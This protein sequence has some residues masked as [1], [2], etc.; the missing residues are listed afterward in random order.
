LGNFWISAVDTL[1]GFAIVISGH[2]AKNGKS[3][4]ALS[5][6]AYPPP[7]PNSVELAITF[8]HAPQ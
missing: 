2:V 8:K 4:K 5:I 3:I 6:S 7:Q 1:P